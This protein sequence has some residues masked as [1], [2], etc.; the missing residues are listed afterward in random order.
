M[1]I[2]I[3]LSMC[4]CI[5]VNYILSCELRVLVEEAFIGSLIDQSDPRP[6]DLGYRY[7]VPYVFEKFL[8]RGTM[9]RDPLAIRT[10]LCQMCADL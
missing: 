8:T 9:D 6:W 7:T 3:Y 4:I 5:Y 1:Y 10:M 2:Y